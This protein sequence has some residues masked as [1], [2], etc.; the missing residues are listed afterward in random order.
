MWGAVA[1][2]I[3]MPQQTC[4]RP[5]NPLRLGTVSSPRQ[6]QHQNAM[7]ASAHT[8]ASK[9]LD[10]SSFLNRACMLDFCY[11]RMCVGLTIT[12]DGRWIV[13]G[14]GKAKELWH[15]LFWVFQVWRF[16]PQGLAELAQCHRS[17]WKG[18]EPPEGSHLH[19][20]AL[21]KEVHQQWT[22]SKRGV[23]S[24]GSKIQNGFWRLG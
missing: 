1:L 3:S 20:Q 10:K 11:T 16:V 12:R 7:Q 22:W 8:A 14:G 5:S 21:Q 15:N 17:M 23:S 13:H 9:E 24:E 6:L 4:L 19:L 18:W 2:L